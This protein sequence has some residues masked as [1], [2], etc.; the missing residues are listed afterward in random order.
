MPLL[1]AAVFAL[2]T[3]STVFGPI[4][5]AL[6]PQHLR[7]EELV[8]GNA[9]IEAGT[10]LSILLGTII[11]GSVVLMANG[12]AL[13]GAIGVV[14]AVIGTV[15]ARFIPPAPAASDADRP[16][17]RLFADSIA[18]VA[19]IV[20][21]RDL[22]LPVLAISWFWTF[23]A[24]II[25]LLPDFA[26]NVLFADGHVVTLM[27]ALFALGVGVGSIVAERL[28]HGEV[29]GRHVPVAALIMGAD[30]DRPLF[31]QHR[32]RPRRVA[33]RL[34]RRSSGRRPT[35]GCSA[36]SSASPPAAGCSRCRSMRC[37]ST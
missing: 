25:A 13:V 33:G 35:G 21:R 27:L 7:D 29:S 1:L 9:L 17:P 26:K 8:A 18:V 15:A 28:L 16:K 4:K 36:I 31:R 22:F 32:P 23:G 3:H 19:H 24:T 11:G 20:R 6:L 12:P 5:Y 14:C 2:G 10:F 30:R 37:S 34:H